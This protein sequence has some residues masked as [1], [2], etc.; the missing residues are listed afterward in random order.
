M[1]LFSLLLLLSIAFG[2]E[3]T[4][5]LTC[6]DK[7]GNIITVKT[8]GEAVCPDGYEPVV[9]GTY[10]DVFS[11]VPKEKR[12]E[13]LKLCT[14]LYNIYSACYDAGRRNLSCIGVRSLA[15]SASREE[16]GSFFDSVSLKIADLCEVACQEG[17]RD[18]NGYSK[19]SYSYFFNYICNK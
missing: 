16:L 12:S 15:F 5:V 19:M 6:R 8:K 2:V 1:F 17:K 7:N 18:P 9:V 4:E 10:P 13:I 3:I 14:P 11:S